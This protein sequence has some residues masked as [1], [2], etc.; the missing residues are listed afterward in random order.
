MR[1]AE[2]I[3]L[4]RDCNAILVPAGTPIVL[5]KD[6]E[7]WL[8]QARGNSFTVHIQGNLARVEGH[9]ADALGKKVNTDQKKMIKPEGELTKTFILDQLRNC[10]DPEIPVNIV[11]LGLIYDCIIQ[12]EDEKG[13]KVNVIMTLTAPG[14]GI[15]P[16][17][18][19]EVKNIVSSIDGVIDV[20][21]ELVFDPPWDR[22]MMSPD[23]KLQM[24]LF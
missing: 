23:A 17:L 1:E 4:V 11:D 10:Y 18:I 9:D 22:D 8:T 19:E 14:C 21:I 20:E 13:F 5:P 2:R 16:V 7:V 15:G 12:P 24:N 3:V 6:S